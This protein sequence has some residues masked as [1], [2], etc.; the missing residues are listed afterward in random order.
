MKNKNIIGIP[1]SLGDGV[2]FRDFNYLNKSKLAAYSEKSEDLAGTQPKKLGS[3]G[4]RVE[5]PNWYLLRQNF[6]GGGFFIIPPE[7]QS[8]LKENSKLYSRK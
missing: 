7:L 5:A 1:V 8:S 6:M 4:H 3:P 2:I